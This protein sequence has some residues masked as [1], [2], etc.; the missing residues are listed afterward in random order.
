MSTT[1]LNQ[2]A[3]T[4]VAE[5]YSGSALWI[6]EVCLAVEER[7]GRE[8][9]IGDIHAALNQVAILYPG[10]DPQ[11][12]ELARQLSFGWYGADASAPRVLVYPKN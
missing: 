2:V 12:P 7:M 4:V 10:D 1:E 5:L 3:A 6:R 8:C 11:R 9:D